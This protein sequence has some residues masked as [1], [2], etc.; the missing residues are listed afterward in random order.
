MGLLSGR[1]GGHRSRSDL[2]WPRSSGDY[3]CTRRKTVQAARIIKT[4]FFFF[5]S[6]R[7][8]YTLASVQWSQSKK[9]RNSTG[10]YQCMNDE[11]VCSV[12][13]RKQRCLLFCLFVAD[14]PW[15][16]FAVR[17]DIPQ[18][19][20]LTYWWGSTKLQ[21]QTR[22]LSLKRV[23]RKKTTSVKVS[24]KKSHILT[25]Q[26]ERAREWMSRSSQMR[27]SL[28]LF[29]FFFSNPVWSC[30]YPGALSVCS[31]LFRSASR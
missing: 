18:S 8:L 5:F 10:P 13:S 20:S 2:Y 15:F 9:K 24:L 4:F 21:A 23:G 22:V 3:Y 7:G 1:G 30:Y 12:S 28:V 6:W 11:L 27:S 29:F 17:P 25:S 16:L 14:R 26:R 31:C 19:Y